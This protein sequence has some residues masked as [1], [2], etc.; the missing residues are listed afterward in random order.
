MFIDSLKYPTRSEDPIRQYGIAVLLT[1]GFFLILPIFI[2]L[3]YY[4]KAIRESAEGEKQMPVFEDYGKLLID[5]IKFLGVT[6]GYIFFMI[7]VLGL[8][9]AIVSSLA[10]TLIGSLVG[11]VL[12]TTVFYLFPS[13]IANFAKR[14][15]FRAA[16]YLGEVIRQ[17]STL[18]Y[19]KAML[20]LIPAF[21][22]VTIAQM[23]VIMG[24]T[25]TLV[26]IPA[27]IVIYPAIIFYESLVYYR[28]IGKS[29]Q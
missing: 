28:L 16:F 27:L 11:A 10:G 20:L 13:S 17:A 4:V 21:I 7:L 22:L 19:L 2:L 15:S 5:G 6:F 9:G 14:D 23:V 18:Q 26:G 25:A 8:T 1:L 29:V 12:G 3:G 24:V